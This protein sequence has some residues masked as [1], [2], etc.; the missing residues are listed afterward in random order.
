MTAYS[1]T[2]AM[3]AAPRYIAKYGDHQAINIWRHCSKM[4][5]NQC[6]YFNGKANNDTYF[7]FIY[8]VTALMK[9]TNTAAG[10][11]FTA[12]SLIWSRHYFEH[13][14]EMRI[15]NYREWSHLRHLT[16]S[17]MTSRRQ[18]IQ[19]K[20]WLLVISIFPVNISAEFGIGE[21]ICRCEYWQISLSS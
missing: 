17:S 7:V 16:T 18:Y 11:K 9:T 2:K 15:F 13:Q 12:K 3:A 1:S 4:S 10:M 6:R 19:P 5:I 21:N 8:S 14:A 20:K